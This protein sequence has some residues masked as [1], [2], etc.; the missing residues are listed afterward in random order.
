MVI[1]F[2]SDTYNFFC[3]SLTNLSVTL[4]TFPAP[5][6]ILSAIVPPK[7]SLFKSR[8]GPSLAGEKGKKLRIA[9]VTFP[10]ASLT[11]P[12]APLMPSAI[13]VTILRPASLKLPKILV[14]ALYAPLIP[15]ETA[16]RTALKAFDTIPRNE[17]KTLL[18]LLR[19]LLIMLDIV[20]RTA[21]NALVTTDFMLF[22]TFE[23]MFL[24]KFQAASIKPLILSIC[25]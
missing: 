23:K 13:D 1:G 14:T 6:L 17:P 2:I 15:F 22:K 4:N 7:F 5:R 18:I 11:C 19:M 9:L 3:I 20:F 12:I 25:P 8:K 21:L 24:I 10:I 16:L